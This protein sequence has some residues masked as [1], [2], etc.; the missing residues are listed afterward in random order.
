MNELTQHI[1]NLLLENDFV[2]I[3]DFGG[4]VAHYNQAQNV[5]AENTFCP[6]TRTIGFNPNLTLND[7]LLVQSYM[8]VHDTDFSGATKMV[9]EAVK[10][11][12]ATLHEDGKVEL[13][14]IGELHYT[15]RHT[16]DFVPYNEK[17]V[18][19]SL[20]GLQAFVMMPLSELRKAKKETA[21]HPVAPVSNRSY[22][23]RLNRTLLRNAVAVAVAV[24]TFF[25][26]S[27]P[28]ENTYMAKGSY[29]QLLPMD[30]F[31]TIE[32]QSVLTTP[33]KKDSEQSQK[34]SKKAAK[35][36]AKE[37]KKEAKKS[38]SNNS[39]QPVNN[40]NN[41]KPVENNSQP[42]NNNSKPVENNSKP[43]ENNSQPVNNNSKPVENN[44][45]PVQNNTQ[46]TKPAANANNNS[47]S[48][49]P[50]TNVQTE[51][52]GKYHVIVASSITRTKAEELVAKLK[53]LG[54]TLATILDNGSTL[55]VS[56]TSSTDRDAAN[57]AMNQARNKDGFSD[58]WV[59]SY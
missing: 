25:A 57:K 51:K 8:S 20:Y 50:A 14:S 17:V 7:G 42:V 44:S 16:Y 30:V 9:N 58:A 53:K 4:F 27:I 5:D 29:A 39:S 2:I 43:V 49:K 59:M 13:P 35:K 10:Q 21:K 32:G 11:L 6:P 24:F 18:T 33:V 40:N 1:E 22:N 28:V 56:L 26:L 54:Y 52:D 12:I 36:A 48:N 55:R 31:E 34:S 15:M 46:Q 3:P 37:A 45:K 19:P 47:V 38:S 23:I 41:S